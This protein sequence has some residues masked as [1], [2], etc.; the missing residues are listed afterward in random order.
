MAQYMFQLAYTSD[1]WKAMVENPQN[2]LEAIRPL[3]ESLGGKIQNAWLSFGEYDGVVIFD[4]PDN[5]SA[6]AFAATVAAGGAARAAKTTP[7][8]SI[9]DAVAA[10]QKAKETSGYKPP[11]A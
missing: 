4:L 7:L 5:V 3:I 8:M 10:M 6:A 1:A 2:R 11:S 9:D